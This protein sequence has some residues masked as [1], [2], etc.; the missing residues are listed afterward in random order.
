MSKRKKAS[1]E[2]SQPDGFAFAPDIEVDLLQGL[3][4]ADSMSAPH[5]LGHRER[6]RERFVAGGPDAL[7]DYELLEL[8]LCSAIPRRDVKP[9]A[10]SLIAEFG[11][12]GGVL[13]ADILA[14]QQIDG[15]KLGTASFLKAVHAAGIRLAREEI[16]EKPVLSSMKELINY[17]RAAMGRATK[18]QFRILFLDQRNRLI[19]DEVQQQGTV[20]HTPVYPREVVKRAL[21]LGAT[22]LIL[23]HNHPSGDATP[24]KADVTM[25]KEIVTAAKALGITIHDHI[26]IAKSDYNS[27]RELGLM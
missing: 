11:T 10:K 23:V 2:Q 24:S 27:F 19:R 22:A 18:E 20:N 8:L 17:C 25:T 14:L 9:L 3:I 26:I 7:P 6:L 16:Q 15:I 5:Y 21:E 12:I 4:P 1:T 13:A